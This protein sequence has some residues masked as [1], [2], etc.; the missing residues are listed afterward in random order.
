MPGEV[1]W[2]T[3][4]KPTLPKPF[5]REQMTFDEITD[6]SPESHLEIL[7]KYSV[8]LPHV[9]W[10]PPNEKTDTIVLAGMWGGAEW[11]GGATYPDGIL[12]F[13]ANETPA[14]LTMINITEGASVG[15]SL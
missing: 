11:G 5:V 8:V 6:I 12:Y 15:E 4:P 7:T 10:M 1:D 2:P 3:Q 13:N 14:M 9:P